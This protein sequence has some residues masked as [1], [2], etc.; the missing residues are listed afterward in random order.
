MTYHRSLTA[1]RW[2]KLS[3]AEQLANIGSEVERALAWQD[4]KNSEYSQHAFER[5][6]ELVDLTL[7]SNLSSSQLE[8][9]SRLRETLVDYFVGDNQCGSS[10]TLWQTYFRSFTYFAQLQ[11]MQ[12]G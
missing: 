3:L 7:K 2:Q 5:A 11:R 12:V 10:P 4:K 9:V 6:L 8:E 1:G